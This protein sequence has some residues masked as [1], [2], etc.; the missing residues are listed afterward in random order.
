MI[1]AKAAEEPDESFVSGCHDDAMRWAK[2]AMKADQKCVEALL[3]LG[4][5][6]QMDGNPDQAIQFFQQATNADPKNFDAAFEV[7]NH[8]YLEAGR[9]QKN[10][11]LW[12]KAEEGFL[13]A[14]RL[15]PKSARTAANV[16]HCKAWR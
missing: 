15:D 12:S 13:A 3:L 5:V 16:A 4:Q 8:W 10:A 9:N 11:D 7:G 2:E 1:K 6:H 14:L